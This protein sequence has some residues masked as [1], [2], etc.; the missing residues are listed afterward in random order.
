MNV[1]WILKRNGGKLRFR[2]LTGPLSEY[3][4]EVCNSPAKIQAVGVWGRRGR[5]NKLIPISWVWL[6]EEHKQQVERLVRKSV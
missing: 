2:T 3:C 6:C 5:S 4:C 1:E